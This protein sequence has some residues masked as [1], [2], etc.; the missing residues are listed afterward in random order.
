MKVFPIKEKGINDLFYYFF[1]IY[2]DEIKD[3]QI[4]LEPNQRLNNGELN[5][6]VSCEKAIIWPSQPLE[7]AFFSVE[8][9]RNQISGDHNKMD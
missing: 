8:K 4:I 9:F 5:N 2:E 6:T 1:N 7:Y 3:N